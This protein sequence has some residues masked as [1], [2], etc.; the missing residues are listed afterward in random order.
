MLGNHDLSAT[1][2]S[3]RRGVLVPARRSPTWR[4][5]RRM[6]NSAQM[7]LPDPVGAATRVLSAVLYSVLN[8]CSFRQI[9]F[10]DIYR[11]T[12]TKPGS[13]PRALS[14]MLQARMQRCCDLGSSATMHVCTDY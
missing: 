8:T 3:Q 11:I 13:G 4:S 5:M 7:V 14:L 9:N 6:A 2:H 1:A 12:S 10:I